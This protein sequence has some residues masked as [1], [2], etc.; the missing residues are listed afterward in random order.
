MNEE[1]LIAKRYRKFGIAPE[2]VRQIVQSGIDCGFS[3][4]TALI[5]ARL[6][7]SIE[8]G[9]HEYFSLEEVAEVLGTSTEEVERLVEENKDELTAK[10]GISKISFKPPFM[11]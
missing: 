6:A 10:G 11:Q 7:L 8:F 4:K 1:K 5:G 9:V 2:V 3:R